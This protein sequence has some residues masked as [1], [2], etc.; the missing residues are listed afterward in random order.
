MSRDLRDYEYEHAYPSAV[1]EYNSDLIP[2]KPMTH[3]DMIRKMSDEELA[4]FIESDFWHFPWCGKFDCDPNE[5]S[6]DDCLLCTL[7]WLK[8]EVDLRC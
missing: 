2:A 6:E 1:I 3:A 5:V 7:D 8:Q 4:K